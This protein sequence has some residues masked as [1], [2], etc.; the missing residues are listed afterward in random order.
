M[1]VYLDYP[2]IIRDNI[3]T[4]R[5]D[6]LE[7]G[8]LLEPQSEWLDLWDDSVEHSDAYAPGSP[9]FSAEEWYKNEDRPL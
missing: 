6:S 7:A 4:R 8:S 5:F 2:E 3:A 9:S 1:I